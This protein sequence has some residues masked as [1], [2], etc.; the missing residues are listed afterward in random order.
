MCLYWEL[1]HDYHTAI[2]PQQHSLYTR[3]RYAVHLLYKSS[4]SELIGLLFFG[5]IGRKSEMERKSRSMKKTKENSTDRSM[6]VFRAHI[7]IYLICLIVHWCCCFCFLRLLFFA[8]FVSVSYCDEANYQIDVEH[9]KFTASW[10][11]DTLLLISR[12]ISFFRHFFF[13]IVLQH[14]RECKVG[15][16]MIFQWISVILLLMVRSIYALIFTSEYIFC[17]IDPEVVQQ[18]NQFNC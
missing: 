14:W 3:C 16:H 1:R 6:I 11:F 18:C 8:L 13:C 15:M 10:L 2:R 5:H 4:A 7:I 17:V 9:S 12:K